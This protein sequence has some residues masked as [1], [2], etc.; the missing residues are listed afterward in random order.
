MLID[1][2][3]KG[4]IVV[5]RQLA[6]TATDFAGVTGAGH[7]TAGLIW[8]GGSGVE[9]H[10]AVAFAGV[11]ETGEEEGL[12]CAV[13][14]AGGDGEGGGGEGGESEEAGGGFGIAGEVG[15]GCVI[16]GV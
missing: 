15:P 14:E 16:G 10:A 13:A 6:A 12:G 8:W 3:L 2:T 9:E 4:G 11:F 5:D 1:R 7:G